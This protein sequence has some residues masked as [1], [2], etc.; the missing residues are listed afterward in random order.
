MGGKVIV[1]SE[2]GKGSI[3]SMT[4]KVMCKIQDFSPIYSSFEHSFPSPRAG[5]VSPKSKNQIKPAESNKPRLL[6]VNDES[7]LLMAY[8]F[9]LE[10][11]FEVT[12][13]ENGVQAL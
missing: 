1:E 11:N 13:A 7:Y 4:F 10:D 8:E 12:T 5:E 9:S 2:I 6:L 3:F